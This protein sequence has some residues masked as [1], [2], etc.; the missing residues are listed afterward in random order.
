VADGIGAAGAALGD[1]AEGE[2]GLGVQPSS[3][4]PRLTLNREGRKGAKETIGHYKLKQVELKRV[5]KIKQW[6]DIRRSNSHRI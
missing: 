2:V 6:S 5:R 1:A 4:I 3:R